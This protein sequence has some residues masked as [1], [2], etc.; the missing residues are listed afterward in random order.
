MKRNLLSLV[1]LV[2]GFWAE[3]YDWLTALLLP[4]RYKAR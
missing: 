2:L 1:L 4:I 3:A